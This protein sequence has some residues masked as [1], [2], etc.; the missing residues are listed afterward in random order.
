MIID[1]A[2]IESTIMNMSFLIAVSTSL[3]LLLLSAVILTL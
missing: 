2:A 1:G 3:L